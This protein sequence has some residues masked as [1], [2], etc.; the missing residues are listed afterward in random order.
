MYTSVYGTNRP[1]HLIFPTAGQ[2]YNNTRLLKHKILRWKV[3]N[4]S[5]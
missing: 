1:K 2:E 3:N 5:G 4:S